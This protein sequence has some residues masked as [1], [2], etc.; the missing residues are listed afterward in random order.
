MSDVSDEL[1]DFSPEGVNPFVGPEGMR[2]VI[3]GRVVIVRHCDAFNSAKT[4]YRKTR[5]GR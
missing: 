5:G 3:L 2:V 1:D 4:I